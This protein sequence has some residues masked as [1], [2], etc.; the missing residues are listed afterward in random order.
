MKNKGLIKNTCHR[1]S[2]IPICNGLLVSANNQVIQPTQRSEQLTTTWYYF[3]E[4]ETDAG[5]LEVAGV[6]P[7]RFEWEA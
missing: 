3:F 7:S 5:E 2:C 1:A 4:I 6:L